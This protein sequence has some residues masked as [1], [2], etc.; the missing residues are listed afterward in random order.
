LTI[1]FFLQSYKKFFEKGSFQ[2]TLRCWELFSIE[3]LVEKQKLNIHITKKNISF[4]RHFGCYKA[5][6]VF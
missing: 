4:F 3:K 5:A 1:G 2:S 6:A